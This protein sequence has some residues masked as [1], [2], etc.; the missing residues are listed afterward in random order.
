MPLVKSPTV[1]TSLKIALGASVG[2]TIS[3][4]ISHP[5]SKLHKRFPEK[6]IKNIS[7]FPYVKVHR[8]DK[9]YHLHHWLNYTSLYT[10]YLMKKRRLPKSKFFNGLILGT[11]LQGLT[12]K[13]RFHIVHRLI[14][15]IES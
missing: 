10:F 9:E 11:I 2:F 12:Y 7:V 5:K 4:L 14:N 1:K 15:N 6:R 13:D 8:K 3:W